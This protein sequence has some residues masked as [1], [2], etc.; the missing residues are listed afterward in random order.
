MT[1]DRSARIERALPVLFDQLAEARTPDYLEAA[2]EHASSSS[3]RPAWTFPER[4][5]PMQLVTARVPTTRVPWRQLG[6]LALIALLLATA[7]AVYVGSQQDRLPPPF[8]PAANG[9]VVYALA[10]DIYAADPA[11]GQ[12]RAIVTGPETDVMPQLSRDGTR[13]AFE[14]TESGATGLSH[15]FTVRLDG[16]DLTRVTTEPVM[17]GP[18]S[19]DENWEKYEFSPDGRTLLI[20]TADGRRGIL[21]AQ[22]DGSRATEVDL[23]QMP[24]GAASVMEPTFRPPDGREILVVGTDGIDENG[25]EGLYAIDPSTGSVRTIA[26]TGPFAHLGS[27]TWSPDGSQIAYVAWINADTMTASTHITR[28]D[29]TGHRVLPM[30]AGA[31]WQA[32][33]AWSNDG[34]RLVAIRGYTGMMED[35]RA[36]VIPSDGSGVGLEIAHEGSIQ[37]ACCPAF[38]WSPDDSMILGRFVDASSEPRQQ[39]IIDPDAGTWRPAPWTSNDWPSWQRVA[40]G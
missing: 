23:G 14:R 35:V 27:A 33:L 13:I 7:I 11:T 24:D 20:A 6:V 34:S 38:E 39:M 9:Q 2:I 8:G 10:G 31:V 30:P 28:A 19:G 40:A 29:G 1:S 32:G 37:G 12:A 16:S 3:Q 25:G 15:V 4:W 22:A 17:I 21:I 5:I 26:V 18:A 36:V